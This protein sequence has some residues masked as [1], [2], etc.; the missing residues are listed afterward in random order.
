MIKQK[1]FQTLLEQRD[2]V[3]KNEA[4]AGYIEKTGYMVDH[5]RIISLRLLLAEQHTIREHTN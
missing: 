2:K 4:T 3:K 5:W 1:Y